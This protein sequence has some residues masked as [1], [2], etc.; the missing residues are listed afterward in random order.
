MSDQIKPEINTNRPTMED[1]MAANP[2]PEK[3]FYDHALMFWD[4]VYTHEAEQK[5][6]EEIAKQKPEESSNV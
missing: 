4:L 5:R 3:Q 6:L 2:T 1:V